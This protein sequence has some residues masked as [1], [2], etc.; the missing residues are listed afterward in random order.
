[1]EFVDETEVLDILSEM[2][3]KPIADG[4]LVRLSMADNAEAV[5]LLIQAEGSDAAPS[6]GVEIETINVP[7]DELPAIIEHILHA[8]HLNQVVLVPVSKWR[9]VFDAVA[10]SMAENEDWQ[11]IDATATIEL[12][13]RDPLL[14]EAGDFNT[15]I[16]LVR[17]LMSDAEDESQ[18]LILTSTTS[19]LIV[20]IVP[21]GIIRIAL[22]N[23]VLADEVAEAF[24]THRG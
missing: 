7:S 13:K 4:E 15:L 24:E 11:E 6:N 8:L 10:F 18:T 22:G 17:A 9:A 23:R 16:A 14:C 1:M 20:E 21:K 19:P 3:I 12:N 5:H 2:S